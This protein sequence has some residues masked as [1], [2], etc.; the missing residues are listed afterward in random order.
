MKNNFVNKN[1][2]Y[3]IILIIAVVGATFFFLAKN[4]KP[5]AEEK[6]GLIDQETEINY[7]PSSQRSIDGFFLG[8]N[9]NVVKN[10]LGEPSHPDLIANQQDGEET[11]IYD[12]PGGSAQ[13]PNFFAFGVYNPERGIVTSIQLTGDQSDKE[14]FLG[15]KLGDS[16]EKIINVL[17][18][19]SKIK[20]G[21]RGSDLYI[22]DGRNYS[23]ELSKEDILF[24][25]RIE[26]LSGF[27]ENVEI[28]DFIKNFTDALN[29]N[30]INKISE[31]LMPDVELY[32]NDNTLKITKRFLDE[33]YDP[34][35]EIIKYL[36]FTQNSIKNIL[37]NYHGQPEMQIRITEKGPSGYIYK[38]PNS[39][40]LEE[41]FVV[42]HA[43]KWRVYE[44]RYRN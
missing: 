41:I 19:P 37:N 29:T 8:Q 4:K 34:N 15:L 11:Y 3:S 20:P 16:K 17:G 18:N 36:L 12:L 22:Y 40:M 35:S 21:T 43:G 14:A 23:V 24:S 33:L 32:V 13:E 10:V 30:N 2:L 42:E 39:K 7:F 31:F 5:N 6:V 38:F 28:T 9:I 27:T 44:I 25:I 1:I 26:G